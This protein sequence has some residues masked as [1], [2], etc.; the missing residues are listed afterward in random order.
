MIIPVKKLNNG[1]QMPMF[2]IGTYNMAKGNNKEDIYSIKKALD[3]GVT[4]IDTAESYSEGETE[5]LVGQAIKN[6]KR[7]SLF[8]VSKVSKENLNYQG[9]NNSIKKTLERLG[10]NYLDV[11]L[12]HQCPNVENF[13]E[14]MQAMDE[15]LKQGLI[16]NIGISNV[17]TKHSKALQGLSKNPIILNQVHYNL[18]FREPEKDGLL[19]HCQK[20]DMFLEAWRPVNKGDMTKSGTNIT[21]SGIKILD[22]MC[23]KYNKTPAQISINWLLSQSFVIT[24]AKSTN[25]IHL[26]ENLGA[27]GWEMEQEDVE[28][29][30]N[31]FPNQKFISDTVP[32]A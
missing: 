31:E 13:A 7:K 26:K 9:I 17:N 14:C 5:K 21:K 22:D 12:L 16:K 28:K 29:L 24:L 27:I 32:L 23:K 25:I 6:H 1:F 20:N 15:I 19:K 8:L 10:T 18:E 2:G 11:Y 4:H 30:K 3:L